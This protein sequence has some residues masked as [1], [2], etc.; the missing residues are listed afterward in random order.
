MMLQGM[1]GQERVYHSLRDAIKKINAYEGPAGYFRGM[2]PNYIKV[3]P[4]VSIS[5]GTY[6]LCKRIWDS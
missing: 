5:F 3:L 6:E 2:V 4:S 1:G